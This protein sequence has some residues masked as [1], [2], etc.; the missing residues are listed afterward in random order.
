VAPSYTPGYTSRQAQATYWRHTLINTTGN[1]N[2]NGA[3]GF[4]GGAG[5]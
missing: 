3:S 5:F 4:G 2:N 1:A